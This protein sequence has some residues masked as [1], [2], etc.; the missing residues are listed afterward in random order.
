MD[1]HAQ[2]INSGGEG[3]VWV[4]NYNGDIENGDLI[5]SSPISGIGQKRDDGFIQSYTVAKVV[6]DCDFDLDSD[7]YECK[8]VTKG[9]KTYRMALL[10][11]VYKCN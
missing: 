10:A 11:C 4:S 9:G 3:A 1:N 6:M 2:I 7:K 5:A 8:E